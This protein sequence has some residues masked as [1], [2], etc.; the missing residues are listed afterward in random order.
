MQA[1]SDSPPQAQRAQRGHR[2]IAMLYAL[3]VLSVPVVSAV[4]D[5]QLKSVLVKHV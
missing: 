4:T 5:T 3:S 2:D 1:T